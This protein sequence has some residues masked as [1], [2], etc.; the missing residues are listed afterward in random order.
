MNEAEKKILNDILKMNDN[1]QYNLIFPNTLYDWVLQDCKPDDRWKI[2][3][4]L[5][6]HGY[7][8]KTQKGNS[9]IIN[10][11]MEDIK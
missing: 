10:I 7:L 11:K 5:V 2:I 3:N 9:Y 1:K 4:G 8:R 6:R